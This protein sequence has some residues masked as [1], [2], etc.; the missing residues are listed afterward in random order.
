MDGID[1]PADCASRGLL[2]SELLNHILWWFGPT[3]L[4]MNE[5]HWPQSRNLAPNEPEEEQ[6]EVCLHTSL[7][8]K[9]PVIPVDRNS[10]FNHLKRITAWI[11]RFIQNSISSGGNEKLTSHLSAQELSMAETYYFPNMRF[12]ARRLKF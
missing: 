6:N 9:T 2:P 7:I 4:H 12:L 1:N 11:L 10:S 3:W 5:E 8:I